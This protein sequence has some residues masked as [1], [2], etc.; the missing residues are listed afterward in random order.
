MI[1]L[2]G[3]VYH[4][5]HDLLQSNIYRNIERKCI[6]EVGISTNKEI[7]EKLTRSSNHTALHLQPNQISCQHIE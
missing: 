3:E 1:V 2:L 5:E 6:H 4:L 7:Q